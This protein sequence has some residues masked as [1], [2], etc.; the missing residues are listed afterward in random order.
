MLQTLGSLPL[1][2]ICFKL[3]IQDLNN[4]ASSSK[5]MFCM[6]KEL[7]ANNYEFRIKCN[8]VKKSKTI[9]AGTYH[10]MGLREDGTVQCWGSNNFGQAPQEV[11]GSNGRKFIQIASGAYHSIGLREDGTVQCW[12][13]N[14]SGQAPQEVCGSNGRK[15]I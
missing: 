9:A 12:G 2:L 5:T 13:R 6:M 14:N 11:H 4:I 8:C 1:E 15:F 3:T 7:Y 10:S